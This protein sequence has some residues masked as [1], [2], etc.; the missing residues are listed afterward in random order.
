MID[1]ILDYNSCEE[2]L[3]KTIGIDLEEGKVTLPLIHT[4]QQAQPEEQEKIKEI[5]TSDYVSSDDFDFVHNLM[6]KYKSLE[7]TTAEAKN[8]LARAHSI[9]KDLPDCPEKE[10]LHFI[11]DY[12]MSRDC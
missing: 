6:K 9:L 10:A 1:D 7:H 12:V 4:L 3:G 5:I 11:T 8:Y 2:N